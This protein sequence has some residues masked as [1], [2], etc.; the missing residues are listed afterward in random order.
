MNHQPEAILDKQK[1]F[2][3][4]E[5]WML[6]IGAAFQ[7][8]N[9]YSTHPSITNT[10][11]K[12]LR[13]LLKNKADQLSK[14]YVDRKVDQTSHIRNIQQIADVVKNFKVNGKPIEMNFGI[15]QKLLNLYL[16]YQ[17]CLGWMEMPP[18]FP[19]DRLIQIKLNK[20][21]KKIKI[22]LRK[23]EAWTQFEN[24]QDYLSVIDFAKKVQEDDDELRE[25]SLAEVELELFSRRSENE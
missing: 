14:L 8:S 22:P 16:K 9:I 10:K 25:L 24:E 23:V 6:S 5:I 7:R 17:W 3:K 13:H 19:V 20:R 18:H 4:N 12:E 1:K 21:A 2:L 11:K 15:A